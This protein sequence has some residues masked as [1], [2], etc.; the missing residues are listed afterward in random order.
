MKKK[1][2]LVIALLL[3]LTACQSPTAHLFGNQTIDT[4]STE[5]NESV[6]SN[7]GTSESSESSISNPFPSSESV[8]E[9]Q[10]ESSNSES[11]EV[12]PI[13]SESE[14]YSYDYSDL[15]DEPMVTVDQLEIYHTAQA[16][17]VIGFMEIHSQVKNNSPYPL[18]G[19]SVQYAYQDEG[20]LSFSIP[21][22][23]NP[24]ETSAVVTSSVSEGYDLDSRTIDS[25]SYDVINGALEQSVTYYPTDSEFYSTIGVE[26]FTF[27]DHP[28]AISEE[29]LNE[30]DQDQRDAFTAAIE[31]DKSY[32]YYDE[33]LISPND[34]AV[35]L[36]PDEALDMLSGSITNNSPYTINFVVIYYLNTNTNQYV[37]FIVAPDIAP[38]G[39]S[40]QNLMWDST[41][42]DA[43]ALQVK[44]MSLSVIT[45]DVE[46]LYRY[47]FV[48]QRTRVVNIDTSGD[49]LDGIEI[50]D[51]SV[52]EFSMPEFSVPE[53]SMPDF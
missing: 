48:S 41:V 6:A 17:D 36:T 9:S 44:A 45:D 53:F 27:D 13:S 40:E 7:N 10:S 19:I 20:Y 1:F 50:P 33:P 42:A 35:S 29:K 34:I 30:L 11:S 23:L 37:S 31:Q 21:V 46:Q 28:S 51:F 12:P 15:Y 16:P 32:G 25:V 38:G 22:T 43:N 14:S 5:K 49:S 39:T 24:G 47:D 52:P 3:V 4:S 2:T 26:Y 8:S 18:T